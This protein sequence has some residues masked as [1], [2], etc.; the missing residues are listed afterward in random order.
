[1]SLGSAQPDAGTLR[2]LEGYG[3]AASWHLE[4]R[5]VDL[6]S[7]TE[8]LVH[9][10]CIIPHTDVTELQPRVETLVAAYEQELAEEGE[11]DLITS[12]SLKDQFREVLARLRETGE[13]ELAL[14]RD[15]F[16]PQLTDLE[17]KTIVAHAVDP[18]GVGLAGVDVEVRRAG[19]ALELVR[20]TREDGMSEDVGGQ[21]PTLPR[22]ARFPVE[23]TAELPAPYNLRVRLGQG[24]TLGDLRLFVMHEYRN[25]PRP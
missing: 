17:L 21:I 4:V 3:P 2:P 22:D 18:Q 7:I 13:A 15:H 25:R 16:A 6:R 20:T 1:M 10:R 23:V 9:I 11:L 14:R 19:T 24:A 5:N 12:F 8:V